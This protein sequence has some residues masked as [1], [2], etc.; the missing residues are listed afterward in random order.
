MKESNVSCVITLEYPAALICC[1]NLDWFEFA[2][3]KA[4]S[5]SS[6]EYELLF[7]KYPAQPVEFLKLQ[8]MLFLYS[9]KEQ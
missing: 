3:E 7:S 6:M 1:V 9:F 2:L 4:V 8:R 5:C